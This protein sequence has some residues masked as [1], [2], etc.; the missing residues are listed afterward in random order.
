MSQNDNSETPKN[1]SKAILPI[2]AGVVIIAG[3]IYFMN[4][5]SDADKAQK[6][7]EKQV[8][9]LKPDMTQPQIEE[10]P[11]EPEPVETQPYVPVQPEPEPEPEP[12]PVVEVEKPK[13]VKPQLPPVEESDPLVKSD[14]QQAYKQSSVA[15]LFVPKDLLQSLVV[16]VDNAA[17]GE[18]L[19][20]HSPVEPP[21]QTFKVLPSGDQYILDPASYQRY[22]PYVNLF[23]QID[24]TTLL[25][26]L[27]KYQPLIEQ[28][29][30]DI[31]Y[32][33]GDFKSTLRRAIDE[34]LDAPLI[35]GEIKLVAPSAM[36][37]FA[38]PELE[39][40]SAIQK[41]MIR[42]GP[43]NQN[44]VQSALKRFKQLLDQ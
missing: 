43:Q 6:E 23:S 32:P 35:Q 14:I 9:A 36:Y 39:S 42:M 34:A 11:V 10:K 8:E 31:G 16:F 30:T 25:D 40:L 26:Y 28:I 29:Y 27:N 2:A 24:S 22:T 41:M 7:D 18:L 19:Q 4:A 37:K 44:K 5:G 20:K 17:R 3:A 15:D 1:Q 12:E 33:N 21:K 13:P 38:D